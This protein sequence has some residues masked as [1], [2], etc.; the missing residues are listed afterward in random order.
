M[1]HANAPQYLRSLDL[2]RLV[3]DHDLFERLLPGVV[4]WLEQACAHEAEWNLDGIWH[5]YLDNSFQVWC[6][7]QRDP[8]ACKGVFV[9]RM[10]VNKRGE[11]SAWDVVFK[12]E[13]LNAALPLLDRIEDFFREQGC[14]YFRILGRPG[15]KK[16]LPEYRTRAVMLEKRLT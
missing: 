5:H 3:P 7:W 15:W 16:K 12:V 13:D 1:T 4:P 9:T 2:I 8:P 10:S 14:S 11:K 6:C